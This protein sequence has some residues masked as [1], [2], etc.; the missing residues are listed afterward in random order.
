MDSARVHAFTDDALGEHDATG[1]AE[2]IAAKEL[3]REEVLEAAIARIEKVQP[4]LNAVLQSDFEGALSAQAVGGPLAG[5]PTIIKDNTDVAG[6]PSQHGSAAFTARRAPSHA[7]ISRLLL[8]LGLTNVGKSTLPE[9]GLNASTEYVGLPPTRNPWNPRYSPGA[10]SGGSAA[11]VAAGA[12]PIAHANDG[13]G[14]IRIPAAAC[15]LI[16]LKPTRGRLPGPPAQRWLPV[17]LVTEG[18][19]TRSVRDTALVF[20]GFERLRPRGGLMPVGDVTGPAKRRLKIGL[21]LDSI[22][23]QPTDEETRGAVKDAATLLEG[24]GH[25]VVPVEI[26]AGSGFPEDFSLYWQLLAHLL[27]SNGKRV[28]SPDFDRSALDP[29][30]AGLAAQYRTNRRRL[31]GV[32]RRLRRS[33]IDYARMFADVDVVLSPVVGHTTPE[34][35]HL[36]PEEGFESLFARLHAYACFTPFNNTSG[37]PA[38]SLPMGRTTGGLPIGVHFS[39]GHGNERT[40]LQLAFEIEEA[41]PW[42]RIQDSDS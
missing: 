8:G 28:F 26:T 39:A 15:G 13:G 9:F 2:L 23:P 25:Q 37:G 12:L 4:E 11:L 20:A 38:I 40:L 41:A 31:P 30:T 33:K 14:S 17:Q 18:V 35:G 6:L 21:V 1:L 42:R 36:S 10:S 34:I 32:I 5:V 22:T 27:G 29:L 7:P 16:G 19:L 3:S 24:M